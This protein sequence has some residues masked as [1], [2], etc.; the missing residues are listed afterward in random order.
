[1]VQEGFCWFPQ[2]MRW[3]TSKGKVAPVFRDDSYEYSYRLEGFRNIETKAVYRAETLKGEICSDNRV[4]TL[5]Q[6]QGSVENMEIMM[7]NLE[8]G[9]SR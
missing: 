9:W 6:I 4:G 1:M 2:L 5:E 7:N 3:N 8:H